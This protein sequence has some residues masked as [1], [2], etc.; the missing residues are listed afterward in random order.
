MNFAQEPALDLDCQ[1]KKSQVY[2]NHEFNLSGI[3]IFQL[4]TK[5]KNYSV[6]LLI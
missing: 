2:Y 3:N 1:S 4:L 5:C 6:L